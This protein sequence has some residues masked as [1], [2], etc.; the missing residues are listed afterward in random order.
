MHI[1]CDVLEPG[2]V[3]TDYLVPGGLGLAD[4]RQAA[5]VL[6][7]S[8][9]VGIEIGEFE[10]IADSD[11]ASESAASL[12]DVLEPICSESDAAGIPAETTNDGGASGPS[13]EFALR[14]GQVR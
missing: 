12:F 8:E 1:H 10:A 4:L 3:L 7:E 6:A 5:E 9:I 11:S 13:Y 2:V 14:K